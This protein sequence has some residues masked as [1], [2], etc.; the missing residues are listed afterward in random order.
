M[1]DDEI[2]HWRTLFG[3]VEAI[4]DVEQIDDAAPAFG[5]TIAASGML[6]NAADSW[7]TH[8]ALRDGRGAFTTPRQRP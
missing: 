3:L 4:S 2:P 6:S 1:K 8:H 7:H 5:T